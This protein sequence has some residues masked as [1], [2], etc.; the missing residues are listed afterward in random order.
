MKRVLV[1]GGTG[2]LG[3][4]VVQ[5]LEKSGYNVM[6]V[7]SKDYDLTR[8]KAC[9]EMFLNTRPD[10]V[11]HLAALCGGILANRQMPGSYFYNNIQMGI[12]I[13]ECSRLG[14]IEKLLLMGSVCSYPKNCPVPFKEDDLWN[15]YPEE[16]N[17]SYGIAKKAVA[18]MGQAYAAQYKMQIINLLMV[19]L[20]GPGD[21][22][23]LEKNHV[24]PALIKKFVDAK[25]AGIPTVRIWGTGNP[26]REFLYVEDAAK[27]IVLALERQLSP[28]PINIG[29]NKE[30][31]IRELVETIKELVGYTGELIW[32]T[33]MPDGQPRRC[34]DV[35]Q[36]A[37]MIGFVAETSL[38]DGLQKTID[39]YTNL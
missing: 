26:S 9:I 37:N 33:T 32:D 36:A 15:G 21:S 30:V 31:K 22:L 8:R 35:S 19:N 13:I 14:G 39:W 28:D 27:A 18:H 4:F 17:A 23:D 7:G 5:Q 6:S 29:S 2:F 24:V 20:Y 10:Y 34:L 11:V 3:K 1:T 38:K 12:N 25:K 16:T